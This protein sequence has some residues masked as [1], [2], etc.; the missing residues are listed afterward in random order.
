VPGEDALLYLCGD[1]CKVAPTD[2]KGR[3][4][5]S[6]APIIFLN[7]CYAG[8]NSPFVTNQFLREFRRLGALGTIATS[9]EVPAVFAASFANEVVQAYIEREGSLAQ[10]MR[11]L[12][13][14]HLDAMNPVPLLYTLQ[15]TLYQPFPTKGENSV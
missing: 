1:H 14:R 8:V 5:F 10:A 2:F 4:P 3:V 15:C 7:S 11:S 9:F 13:L 6:N 12:R